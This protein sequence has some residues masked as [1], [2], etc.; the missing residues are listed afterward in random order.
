MIQTKKLVKKANLMHFNIIIK[1]KKKEINR[2]TIFD[3]TPTTFIITIGE[4]S[5]YKKF[6]ENS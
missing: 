2:F 5:E 6:N 4:D 1:K 3:A